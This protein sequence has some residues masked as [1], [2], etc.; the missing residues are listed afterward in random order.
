MSA[1]RHWGVSFGWKL[2]SS[3]PAQ[4]CIWHKGVRLLPHSLMLA[5]VV[6]PEDYRKSM[7][8]D[9]CYLWVQIAAFLIHCSKMKETSD[10][11]SAG[12]KFPLCVTSEAWFNFQRTKL[13]FPPE[14]LLC[15]TCLQRAACDNLVEDSFPIVGFSDRSSLCAENKFKLIEGLMQPNSR[16]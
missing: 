16:L 12:I 8:T 2:E 13:A 7:E 14:N 10:S 4:F 9:R 1:K 5:A 3:P 6:L 11:F 15:P